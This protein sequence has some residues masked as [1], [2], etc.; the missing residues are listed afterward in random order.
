MFVFSVKI[1]NKHVV[2]VGAVRQR[3]NENK[4]S[5]LTVPLA[6][7]SGLFVRYEACS[8]DQPLRN[9]FQSE[10]EGNGARA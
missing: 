7:R 2:A 8:L 5:K 9:D 3:G 6:T 10:N 1:N 4:L